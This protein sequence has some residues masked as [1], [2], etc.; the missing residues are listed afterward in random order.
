MF[1]LIAMLNGCSNLQRD[2][3]SQDMIDWLKSELKSNYLDVRSLPK[4]AP[5]YTHRMAR[6]TMRLCGPEIL[7]TWSRMP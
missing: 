5:F 1:L 2:L 6:V 7:P 4:M 3:V